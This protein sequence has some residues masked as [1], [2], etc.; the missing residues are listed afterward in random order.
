MALQAEL[1]QQPGYCCLSLMG[2]G[3]Q[4]SYFPEV[5]TQH[6]H[7]DN[8][9]IRV[10][11]DE[12]PLYSIVQLFPLPLALLHSLT[13]FLSTQRG[14]LKTE[15]RVIKQGL[16]VLR[17]VGQSQ[18]DSCVY[19]LWCI[20]KIGLFSQTQHPQYSAHW[21]HCYYSIA[22]LLLVFL[23]Q[24]I[25]KD[26]YA[27]ILVFCFVVSF[28][29]FYKSAKSGSAFFFFFKILGKVVTEK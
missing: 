10:K 28:F 21:F 22:Y 14:I 26:A 24:S 15:G 16:F 13:C 17:R 9:L 20:P 12:M 4:W 19:C 27:F 5:Q 25:C 2:Y 18:K 11:S 29:L 8:L 1:I 3:S 23:M 6:G 7:K